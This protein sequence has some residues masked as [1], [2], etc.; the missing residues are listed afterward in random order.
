VLHTLCPEAAIVV[1]TDDD[2]PES[3]FSSMNFGVRGY[4]SS[5]IAPE[6]ASQVLS[7]VLH[8]GTYFPSDAILAALAGSN[9]ALSGRISEISSRQQKQTAITVA[10]EGVRLSSGLS[11]FVQTRD[12]AAT[13]LAIA[14]L[15][16]G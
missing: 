13:I 1:L 4:L 15:Q 5:S 9:E 10:E 8:G 12:A 14:R 7:F 3:I 2:S 16:K 11:N 6:L